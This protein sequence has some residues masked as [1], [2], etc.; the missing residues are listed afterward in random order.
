MGG[1]ASLAC[2]TCRSMLFGGRLDFFAY[3]QARPRKVLADRLAAAAQMLSKKSFGD[4]VE[5]HTVFRAREAVPLVRIDDICHGQM[6]VAHGA[7]DLVGL[8]YLAA[9]V[10]GSVPDQQRPTN[11][12]HFVKRRA[13]P[14]PRATLLA[15]HVGGAAKHEL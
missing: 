14:E 13:R 4:G 2:P 9:H 10:V 7:H 15:A 1:Y 6:A 5:R 3:L 8:L 12:V 11:P